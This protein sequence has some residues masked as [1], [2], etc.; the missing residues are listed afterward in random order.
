MNYKDENGNSSTLNLKL[1]DKED[2][3]DAGIDYSDQKSWTGMICIKDFHKLGFSKGIN[4]K[5]VLDLERC[6]KK[7]IYK[8]YGR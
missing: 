7:E 8:K 4:N 5:I 2:F 3:K 6:N 1:C